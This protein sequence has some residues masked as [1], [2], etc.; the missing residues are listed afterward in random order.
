MEIPLSRFNNISLDQIQTSISNFPSIV[1]DHK[2]FSN[3]KFSLF[4]GYYDFSSFSSKNIRIRTPLSLIRC[5]SIKQG[6]QPKPK[7]KPNQIEL[8]RVSD[9]PSTQIKKPT[10]TSGLCGEIEKLV[11]FRRYKDALELF[12][13]VECESDYYDVGE[14]TYD[15]LVKACIELKSIRGVKRVYNFMMRSGFEAD[16]YMNNR[17]L[18]MHVKC[19]M[20]IDARRL[21]DEMPRK[22][23]VSWNTIIVG[24]VDS[25]DYEVAFDLFMIMWREYH[26]AGSR[27]FVTM[28]RAS[29]GLGCDYTGRQLHSNALKMGIN[30]DA[31]VSCGLINMY[32]KCGFVEDA[33]RAF[34]EMPEKTVV[35]WNTIIAGY[36]LHGYSEEALT[37]YFEMQ[38]SGVKMDHFTYSIIISICARLASV[39]HAKQAHAGLVRNGFVSDLEA[40]TALVDFYGKWGKIED[41]RRVFDRMPCKNLTSWNAMIAGYSNHGI[42]TEAV[43]MFE[44]MLREGQVPNHVTFLA[45]LSGC[46]HSG[47]SDQGWEIFESMGR[48][49]K[50][51]PRAMHYACMIQLLGREGLLDE[52]LAMIRDAPFRPTENMWAAL[53]NACR[54]HNNLELG[55]FAAEKLYGMEPEKLS[56]YVV[57]MNIYR[58]SG[59]LEEA[60]D[61]VQTLRKRG[62]RMLPACSWIEVKKQPH[63]FHSGDKSHVQAEDIYKQLDKMMQEITKH[64]YVPSKKSLLPDVD[65]QEDRVLLY[66]SEKLAIAF[67]LI[68]TSASTSLQVV[69]SH[70]ICGDCHNVIKLIAKISQRE[71]VVRDASR[72]HHFK[73]GTCSCGDYW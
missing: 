11:R 37:M 67:G 17:V 46:A 27:T 64:G 34:D 73:D 61:V 32:S 45:V 13:I 48:K 2:L 65:K 44:Q 49:Y 10:N 4:N 43:C 66:H 25:G 68:S 42:G 6:L 69:Q 16:Q 1:L 55:K 62:L 47:L 7:P 52:A 24:L 33:Q 71:I 72:F 60:A 26:D 40:N 23:V 41:A 70:R 36:A 28:I 3:T 21:F 58:S 56:N 20:M 53:L 63:C 12:E 18:L 19:G 35:G 51:K 8:E 54:V 30:E 29:A 5:S 14:S 39:E 31:F 22:N 50:V 15:A 9:K 59:R 57:L 38:D